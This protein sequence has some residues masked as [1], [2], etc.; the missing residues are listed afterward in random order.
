MSSPAKEGGGWTAQAERELV[1]AVWTSEYPEGRKIDWSRVKE[2]MDQRGYGFTG[3]AMSTQGQRWS[4][5][6]MKQWRA[7]LDLSE[8]P[9]GRKRGCAAGSRKNGKGRVTEEMTVAALDAGGDD[10]DPANGSNESPSAKRIKTAAND[11]SDTDHTIDFS[12]KQKT[13][14]RRNVTSATKATKV[15]SDSEE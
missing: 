14:A 6:I 13:H 10:D 8:S 15:E 7:G 9:H 11:D 5:K 2:I 12:S 1:L 3:S 4:K